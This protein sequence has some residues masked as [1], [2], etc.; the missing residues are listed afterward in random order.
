[1]PSTQVPRHEREA[2]ASLDAASD[3]HLTRDDA[4]CR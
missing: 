3:A 1:M 2:T 4:E